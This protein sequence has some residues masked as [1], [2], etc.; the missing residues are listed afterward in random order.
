MRYDGVAIRA[1]RLGMGLR[2]LSRIWARAATSGTAFI[3]R[4]STLEYVCVLG[5]CQLDTGTCEVARLLVAL[6]LLAGRRS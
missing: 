1:Q 4:N 6:F 2:A 5:A 3:L